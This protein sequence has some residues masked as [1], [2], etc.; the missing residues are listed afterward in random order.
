MPEYVYS[1]ALI[2]KA[3]VKEIFDWKKEEHDSNQIILPGLLSANL[4]LRDAVKYFRA[5]LD[6]AEQPGY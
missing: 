1:C 3:K 5:G 4:K 6:M 2:P